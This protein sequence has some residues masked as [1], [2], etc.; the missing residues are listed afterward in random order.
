MT[1]RKG[2]DSSP[3]GLKRAIWSIPEIS[4]LGFDMLWPAYFRTATD[5]DLRE[6]A[7]LLEQIE[8]LGAWP[9]VCYLVKVAMLENQKVKESINGNVVVY[10]LEILKTE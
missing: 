4:G 6:L 2:Q 7:K 5:E 9:T 1:S 10:I 8:D 3:N